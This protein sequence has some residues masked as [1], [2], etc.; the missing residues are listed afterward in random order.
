MDFAIVDSVASQGNVVGNM[1][2]MVA[3]IMLLA[4]SRLLLSLLA[5]T[6]ATLDGRNV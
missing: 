3:H 2:T 5:L 6:V 1:P 4:T